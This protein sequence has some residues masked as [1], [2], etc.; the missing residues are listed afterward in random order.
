MKRRGARWWLLLPFAVLLP[1]AAAP[2]QANA[3]QDDGDQ[4]GVGGLLE[5]VA[6]QRQLA[7]VVLL[8]ESRSLMTTDPDGYRVALSRSLVSSLHS[9]TRIP[10]D[11]FRTRFDLAVVGFSSDVQG[12]QGSVPSDGDWSTLDSAAIPQAV[13]ARIN[14]F[15]DRMDGNDTDYVIALGAAQEMLLRRAEVMSPDDPSKVCTAIL[16]FTD[17]KFDLTP[18]DL[19]RPWA[20]DIPISSERGTRNAVT[21]GRELLCS[22]GGIADQIR[23]NGTHLFA[24][25]LLSDAFLG[26]DEQLLRGTALGSEGCGE[27]SA[28]RLGAYF[29]GDN[30]PDLGSCFLQLLAGRPCVPPPLDGPCSQATPC[31]DEVVV[32]DSIGRFT[33]SVLA[34]PDVS[35]TTLV[36]PSGEVLR[37]ADNLSGASVAGTEL[38]VSSS[39]ASAL[40]TATVVGS[41]GAATGTWR[42]EHAPPQGGSLDVAATFSSSIALQLDGPTEVVR[43]TASDFTVQPVGRT[44]QPVPLAALG[45]DPTIEVEITDGDERS[46]IEVPLVDTAGT[47]SFSLDLPTAAAAPTVRLIGTARGTSSNGS[48][49]EAASPS[50]TVRA[51][52]PGLVSPPSVVSIGTIGVE[53]VDDRLDDGT[54]PPKAVDTTFEAGT[55]TGARDVEGTACFDGVDWAGGTAASLTAAAPCLT[56]APGESKPFTFRLAIDSPATGPLVGKARFTVTSGLDGSQRTV[57]VPVTGAVIVAAPSPYTDFGRVW[58]W[59]ALGITLPLVLYVLLAVSA[60]KFNSPSSVSA[61]AFTTEVSAAGLARLEASAPMAGA[62]FEFLQVNR[63]DR[64]VRGAGLTFTAPKRLVRMATAIVRPIAGD[65]VLVSERGVGRRRSVHECEIENKLHGQWVF[66]ADRVERERVHGTLVV[67]LMNSQTISVMGDAPATDAIVEQ[68]TT[69][70]AALFDDIR[71]ALPEAPSDVSSPFPDD[72]MSSPDLHW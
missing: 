43:G 11:G 64:Q 9:V 55:V 27:V 4:T 42:V 14:Q 54:Q 20:Q 37:L 44:G 24:F 30:V 56:V 67:L 29:A 38:S 41:D 28:E 39:G 16:W 5:C 8:D 60:S 35:A 36:S 61:Q 32:D 62:D 40:I 59:L 26:E 53:R 2:A 70:L 18:S 23:V 31:I 52:S 68:A 57:T 72:Q 49:F 25:A 71:E 10:V 22:S 17:G 47:L 13:E 6:E 12:D 21:R 7:A 50:L 63:R 15:V 65:P 1:L 3:T 69:R 33:V 48:P 19:R 66:A 46:T 34:G 58:L 51:I 45:A